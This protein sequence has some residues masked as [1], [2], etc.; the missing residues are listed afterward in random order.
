MVLITFLAIEL[1]APF[2]AREGVIHP[3]WDKGL[4]WV[5][6]CKYGFIYQPA[7]AHYFWHGLNGEITYQFPNFNGITVEV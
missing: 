4:Y 5:K 1:N 2:T 3:N 7:G 6:G